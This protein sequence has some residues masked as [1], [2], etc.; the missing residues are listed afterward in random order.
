MPN[1]TVTWFKD[2]LMLSIFVCHPLL[3]SCRLTIHRTVVIYQSS[4]HCHCITLL[5][6]SLCHCCYMCSV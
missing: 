1:T 4:L 5:I 2:E 6:R 3:A